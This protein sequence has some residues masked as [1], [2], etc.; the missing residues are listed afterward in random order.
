MHLALIIGVHVDIAP[1]DCLVHI[2]NH[3]KQSGEK[4]MDLKAV[5]Q[6]EVLEARLD[7]TSAAPNSGL[8]GRDLILR[9][10]R[11][12]CSQEGDDSPDQRGQSSSEEIVAPRPTHGPTDAKG[13]QNAAPISGMLADML[14]EGL[15][16]HE[17][18]IVQYTPRSSVPRIARQVRV[19][20]LDAQP[21]I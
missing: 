8:T 1:R 3:E 17:R 18:P 11:K 21:C 13:S 15:T 14:Q 7:A 5:E 12:A 4:T 2:E 6:L 10:A 9:A 16:V 19:G 20:Q